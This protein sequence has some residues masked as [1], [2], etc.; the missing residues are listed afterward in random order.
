MTVVI[1]VLVGLLFLGQTIFFFRDIP[2]LISALIVGFLWL[3]FI[4]CYGFHPASYEYQDGAVV[5]KTPFRSFTY[6]QTE[7]EKVEIL[8][9]SAMKGS[10]RTFGVGGVFGYFGKF[11]NRSIGGMTWYASQRKNWVLLQTKKGRKIILTPDDPQ[12]FVKIIQ[13]SLS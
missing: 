10:I 4:L 7:I 11:Y 6:L 8:E 12:G 2:T 9:E 5:V 3:I 13:G 1:T